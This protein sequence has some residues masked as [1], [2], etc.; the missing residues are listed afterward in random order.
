M[1]VIFILLF[2]VKNNAVLVSDPV[3]KSLILNLSIFI[4]CQ[5]SKVFELWYSCCVGFRNCVSFSGKR[6][7]IMGYYTFLF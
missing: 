1:Y 6:V 3:K 5:V 4:A 7:F 2:L